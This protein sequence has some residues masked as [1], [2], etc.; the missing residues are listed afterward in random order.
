MKLSALK[1]EHPAL[2]KM[3]FINFLIFLC[4]IF[5]L[6]D[7][8]PLHW[9]LVSASIADLFRC[10]QDYAADPDL[11]PRCYGKNMFRELETGD[12]D[13]G[14][15]SPAPSVLDMASL[16]KQFL[17]YSKLRPPFRYPEAFFK[18]NQRTEK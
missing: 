11:H 4:V 9:I 17:R 12:T 6:L 15:L 8:N 13:L 1:R 14:Q 3:K 7:P 2:Q 5:A 16:L 10:V 18:T